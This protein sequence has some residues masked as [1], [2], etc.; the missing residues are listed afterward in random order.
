[1]KKS[2]RRTQRT[3][4][5]GV[6]F[7]DYDF[8]GS[9]PSP[10]CVLG[11]EKAAWFKDTEGNYLCIHEDLYERNPAMNDSI[12]LM[13]H[14]SQPTLRAHSSI[15]R[16]ANASRAR[17]S[18]RVRS[19]RVARAPAILSHGPSFPSARGAGPLQQ[20]RPASRDSSRRF[21]SQS[22]WVPYSGTALVEAMRSSRYA[23]MC[24]VGVAARDRF[25]EQLQAAT[26]E[27]P[28]SRSRAAHAPCRR[29]AVGAGKSQ[30]PASLHIDDPAQHRGIRS[31][32]S[33]LRGDTL[34]ER[35]ICRKAGAHLLILAN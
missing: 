23:G 6:V 19:R 10:V 13:A 34:K 26:L 21:S 15:F 25:L 2:N 11:A 3:Q 18:I 20:D 5:A 33:R 28:A 31:C 8:P 29:R 1:M 4:G 16:A 27:N 22:N 9:R 30:S 35:P 12:L 7:E 24:G 14:S 17:R 32:T